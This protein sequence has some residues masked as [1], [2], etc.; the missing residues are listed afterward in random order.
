MK[1]K[2]KNKTIDNILWRVSGKE[3]KLL[4]IVFSLLE[5]RTNGNN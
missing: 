1:K 4:L 3:H 5:P 2:S